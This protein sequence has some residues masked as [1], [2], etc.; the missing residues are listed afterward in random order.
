MENKSASECFDTITT[1]NVEV[2]EETY[3]GSTKMKVRDIIFTQAVNADDFKEF[4]VY[5]QDIE[6]ETVPF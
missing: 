6:T 1:F 5:L 2:I 3:K 4:D